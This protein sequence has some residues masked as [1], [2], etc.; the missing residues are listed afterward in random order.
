MARAGYQYG[1]V[2]QGLRAAWLDGQDVCAELVLPPEAAGEAG[3]FGLHPALLD[4]SLHAA[5]FAP[6]AQ[7]Q[8]GQ[9]RLPFAWTG[10]SL[11]ASGA[12]ALRVRLRRDQSG[13]LSLTAA[14]LAGT[15]V[16]TV[17][18]LATRPVV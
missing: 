6:G 1:P 15:P 7:E 16:I 2:F 12:T 8:D 10:V 17:G 4:A 5:W 18:S 3:M 14:D 11:H 9:V 13:D